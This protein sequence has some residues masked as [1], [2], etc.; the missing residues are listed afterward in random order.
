MGRIRHQCAYVFQLYER[1]SRR[2]HRSG[3]Y[4]RSRRNKR[5]LVYCIAADFFNVVGVYR[6]RIC[7]DLN[8]S[9]CDNSGVETLGYYLFVE[10]NSKFGAGATAEDL[11]QV[12]FYA[13]V[14]LIITLVVAPLTIILRKLLEKYGPSEN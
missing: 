13:T 9:K 5:V 14:S 11:A 6:H 8:S 4:R 10:V 3:A 7:G 2:N 1:N 12:P